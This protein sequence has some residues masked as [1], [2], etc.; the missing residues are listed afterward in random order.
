M[1]ELDVLL[2]GYLEQQYPN[3]SVVEQRVFA[4]LLE[5]QDP[6]L[7]AYLTG[8]DTPTDATLADVIDKITTTT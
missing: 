6:L 4:A 5:L 7:Y 2:L 3:A 1:R 8:R